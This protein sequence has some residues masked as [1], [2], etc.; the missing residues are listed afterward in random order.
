[1]DIKALDKTEYHNHEKGTKQMGE[2]AKEKTK[3]VWQKT[4]EKYVKL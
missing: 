3:D 2:N 4:E 1:M